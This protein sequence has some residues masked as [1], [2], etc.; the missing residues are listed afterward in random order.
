MADEGKIT[1]EETDGSPSVEINPALLFEVVHRED[2]SYRDLNG[3]IRARDVSDYGKIRQLTIE[4]PLSSISRANWTQLNTWMTGGT[5]VRVR[6]FASN[7][8]YYD[9]TPK[10]FFGRIRTLDAGGYSEA[11]MTEPP[12][13]IIIDVDR[14]S[15]S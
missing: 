3:Y 11:K 13:S 15:A 7:S 4:V 9:A 12:Y 6:D 8:T 5:E 14:F 10:Y 2:F 1:I